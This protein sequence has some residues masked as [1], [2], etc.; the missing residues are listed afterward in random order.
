MNTMQ[1]K[2]MCKKI[3]RD[4]S[5]KRQKQNEDLTVLSSIFR[6]YNTT[7][8]DWEEVKYLWVNYL[9]KGNLYINTAIQIAR[10]RIEEE[11]TR[12]DIEETNAS[13]NAWLT[14]GI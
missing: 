7:E 5:T 9:E 11:E 4:F 3:Y 8:I 6:L 12:R 14:Q 13:L 1:I 10:Q 2:E